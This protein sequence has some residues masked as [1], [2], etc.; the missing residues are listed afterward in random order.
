M[1]RGLGGTAHT[2]PKLTFIEPTHSV[3]SHQQMRI[4]QPHNSA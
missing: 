1:G 4:G 3:M 2:A